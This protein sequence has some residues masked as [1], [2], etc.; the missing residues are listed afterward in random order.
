MAT[1]VG[2]TKGLLLRAASYSSIVSNITAKKNYIVATIP[3]SGKNISYK[4][5]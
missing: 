5:N 1:W 3:Q 4:T 2:Q